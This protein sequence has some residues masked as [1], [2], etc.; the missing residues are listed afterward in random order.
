MRTQW[1]AEVLLEG[2]GEKV[3]FGDSG[4]RE[5]ERVIA[6]GLHKPACDLAIARLRRDGGHDF[7][8]RLRLPDG[9]LAQ[10]L[11]YRDLPFRVILRYL[12]GPHV[13]LDEIGW[14]LRVDIEGRIGAHDS[15][16]ARAPLGA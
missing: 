15:V 16:D 6:E 8:P 7:T 13:P 3:L 12:E 9:V 10:W 4:N 11:T 2:L 14:T 5:L 1:G